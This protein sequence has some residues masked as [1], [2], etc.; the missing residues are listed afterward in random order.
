M[1][2]EQ[3]STEELERI[4]AGGAV[5]AESP[6]PG[7]APDLSGYSTEALERIAA[8][9]DP[10]WAELSDEQ[11]ERIAAPLS[12]LPEG[13][14]RHLPGAVGDTL[15][16]AGEAVTGLLSG[17][18][19]EAASQD[20]PGSTIPDRPMSG[21]GGDGDRQADATRS[22]LAPQTQ[23]MSDMWAGDSGE[24]R[25]DDRPWILRHP[26]A[27][28]MYE[29]TLGNVQRVHS[30]LFGAVEEAQKAG[31]GEAVTTRIDDPERREYI[32]PL[33]A[34]G[35]AMAG[36]GGPRYRDIMKNAGVRFGE[37]LADEDAHKPWYSLTW[38]GQLGKE[39]S[40]AVGEYGTDPLVIGSALHGQQMMRQ[41]VEAI[42]Q[43]K[44]EVFN[45]FVARGIDVKAAA[46]QADNLVN[47]GLAYA[48]DPKLRPI[49]MVVNE[50]GRIA[51][52]SPVERGLVNPLLVK[53]RGGRYATPKPGKIRAFGQR[54]ADKIRRDPRV[55]RP[56][57]T[58]GTPTAPPPTPPPPGPSPKIPVPAPGA[59]PPASAPPAA[60]PVAPPPTPPTP[61]PPVAEGGG[62]TIIDAE[63]AARRGQPRADTWEYPIRNIVVMDRVKQFKR[64]AD[65]VTGVVRGQALQ[66]KFQREPQVQPILVWERLD[67]KN[68]V[69]TGR[70]RFDLAKRNGEE[71]IPAQVV[72]EADG[73]TQEM[74][75][76]YD[77][78]ANIRDQQGE[79]SDY[80]HFFRHYPELT[81]AQAADK[82]LVARS[83]GQAGW[84]LG[85]N[86]TDDLYSLYQAGRIAEAK[87]VAIAGAAP[88]NAALQAAGIEFARE[89]G[90]DAADV[91]NYLQDL[92]RQAAERIEQGVQG[93]LVGFDDAAMNESKKVA[94]AASRRQ[95]D[96]KRKLQVLRAGVKMGSKKFQDLAQQY[97][98]NV[99]DPDA[100]ER[101]QVEVLAELEAWRRWATDPSKVAELQAEV[102]G[103]KPA[104]DRAA[105]AD[106]LEALRE[107]EAEG[108][109]EVREGRAPYGSDLA[110]GGRGESAFRHTLRLA[111]ESKRGGAATVARAD[112]L[113]TRAMQH[114][115]RSL[116][117][118]MDAGRIDEAEAARRWE[119]A[120]AEI[121][122]G[123]KKIEKRQA[124]AT[125]RA[126]TGDMFAPPGPAPGMLFEGR[127][128]YGAAGESRLDAGGASGRIADS[129][130]VFQFEATDNDL[131]KAAAARGVK[132][133]EQAAA[134]ADDRRRLDAVSRTSGQ[135]YPSG[136]DRPAEVG[137][138]EARLLTPDEARAAQAQALQN[139]FNA[140]YWAQ[141][142]AH[143]DTVSSVIAERLKRPDVRGWN[144]RG[145]RVISPRD[146]AGVHMTIDA[147]TQEVFAV[148]YLDSGNRTIETRIV[149][150]GL[151]DSSLVH[152]REI[153]G[154]MPKG[155]VMVVT[156]HNHP[157]G[158]PTPSSEDVRITRQLNEAAKLANVKLSDHVVTN[159]GKYY[160]MR[161]EG[162]V[163]FNADRQGPDEPGVIRQSEFRDT[164]EMPAQY[165]WEAVPRESLQ[166]IRT[167]QDAAGVAEA[168]SQ[169]AAP[170][171][172]N[173]ILYLNAKKRLTAV[174]RVP[175]EKGS[176]GITQTVAQNAGRHGASAYIAV[177]QGGDLP[178]NVQ[179]ARQL[180]ASAKT[181]D[182]G[183]LDIMVAPVLADGA[184]Q[185][186]RTTTL[187]P[188][189][190]Q[191]GY[192]SMLER[193][194]V[195]F[196]ERAAY[197]NVRE[198]G[199]APGY[200]ELVRNDDLVRL[201]VEAE[202]WALEH[203]PDEAHRRDA[204]KVW[205]K[206]AI[207]DLRDAR[208]R[209]ARPMPTPSPK[210]PGVASGGM[211]AIPSA[212]FSRPAGKD[213][214]PAAPAKSKAEERGVMQ[215]GARALDRFL[216]VARPGA[217]K[218]AEVGQEIMRRRIAEAAR[219]NE[220]WGNELN[221]A[222]WQMMFAPEAARWGFVHEIEAGQQA[223]KPEWVEFGQKMRKFLD[224]ERDAIRAI[225]P[226]ALRRFYETYFPHLW[227]SG[228]DTEMQ[229]ASIIGRRPLKGTADFLKQRTYAT[230][231]EGI[232]AGLVPVTPNPAEM[233]LLK[234]AEMRRFRMAHEILN[235]LKARG[236]LSF[237]YARGGRPP[238]GYARIEDDMFR[239]ILP[240]EITVQEAYDEILMQGLNRV[241]TGMGI[242]VQTKMKMSGHRW[243][244]AREHPPQIGRK[245]GGPESVLIHEIGHHLGY[246]YRLYDV[247][248]HAGKGHYRE[249]SRGPRKGERVFVPDPEAVAHRKVIDAEWR[250][251]ADARYAGKEDKVS[252]GFK[253]YVRKETEKE[254]VLLEAFL[255]APDLF[256]EVAPRL[257]NAFKQFMGSHPETVELMEL[258][259]SL[260]LGSN[261]DKVQVPGVTEVGRYYAPEPVAR[262]LNNHLS[263]GLRHL[264]GY[265]A[266]R[267]LGNAVNQAQLSVSAFHAGN[268]LFDNMASYI[269][270]GLHEILVTGHVG[271]G[272]KHIVEGAT[273]ISAVKV[274]RS[275][276]RTMAAYRGKKSTPEIETLLDALLSA[277]GRV[278]MDPMYHNQAVK[279]LA[280]D[281]VK[282][283]DSGA[284][285]RAGL[286]GKLALDVA[287]SVLELLNKPLMEYLVPRMK[288]GLFDELARYEL[289]RAQEENW[290]NEVLVKRLMMA[291]DS[292]ENRQGQMSYDNLFWNRA[293]KDCLM[294]SMRS[295]GWNLGTWQEYGGAL[296]DAITTPVRALKGATRKPLLN[297]EGKRMDAP[298]DWV[299]M[300][301]TYVAG[302]AFV[303][304]MLGAMLYYL[305]N[306]RN[307]FEDPEFSGARDLVFVP[308]G[309]MRPDGSRDRIALPTY[310]KDL[311]AYGTRPTQTV[312]NKLHPLWNSIA[313]LLQN[314]DFYGTQV[315]DPDAPLGDQVLQAAEYG[316][317][318][319]E[320]FSVRNYR[321]QI[322]SGQD[323]QRAVGAFLGLIPAP[324]YVAR[325]KTLRS[326]LDITKRRAPIGPRSRDD[327][328]RSQRRRELVRAMRMDWPHEITEQDNLW[329]GHDGINDIRREAA[330]TY[331]QAA[332]SR[333]T[334]EDMARIYERATPREQAELRPIV[335]NRMF[336]A[337]VK[338]LI[339]GP[340]RNRS[341][342]AALRQA[343]WRSH[344]DEKPK[345]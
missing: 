108:G 64:G 323:P 220:R 116:L 304:A 138:G 198:G 103:T 241:A 190:G 31:G 230:F 313:Y 67:G 82:G 114:K 59:T 77:A 34:F 155:T 306:R 311:Y 164:P 26:V 120:Q 105:P 54:V 117:D 211:A 212:A 303:T 226:Y 289:Q 327:A 154:N 89:Q 266:L 251:L 98:I 61:T 163:E 197:G 33:A 43:A 37:D 145:V 344:P 199:A 175:V 345:D 287:G 302:A 257:Y 51:R 157:S 325:S 132:P 259:P 158:D 260:V 189:S 156:S 186:G 280:R 338:R 234:L 196:E 297:A 243:G 161:E 159:A 245:F 301:M 107:L 316:V 152:P 222:V 221:R 88:G 233:V 36:Y 131:F 339:S 180:V 84:S 343:Y 100:I 236:Q 68:E 282:W 121:E 22:A 209:E 12:P 4:A 263:P 321:Q 177:L 160:S 329:F 246:R 151:V 330:M 237:V 29:A 296:M 261:A 134:A 342:S 312:I 99:K 69:V 229:I 90:V 290:S 46:I 76:R 140:E 15:K 238:A 215:S 279:T 153:F 224:A 53:V 308:T 62:T 328:A 217:R 144:M 242:D 284:L 250:A 101:A 183:C 208:E 335:E 333:L 270:L 341:G 47:G 102:R 42:N 322:E 35:R 78:E 166:R 285:K 119:K 133:D 137:A 87:A 305:Y 203:V 5:V 277:G 113:A 228:P 143:G 150:V 72:R 201:D 48:V 235:D 17:S 232:E 79:I 74:A 244:E 247:L 8:G 291:W 162:L 256:Q 218:G 178:Y 207:R 60:P 258:R 252:D 192:V 41:T 71:T 130:G 83:K 52:A 294:L 25:K 23:A 216:A 6:G 115:A 111:A 95:N 57:V 3:Y 334:P 127:G 337:S 122:R 340:E 93:V 39:F 174:T 70:N 283:R 193:G 315:I 281:L 309:A 332:F 24:E 298:N 20:A 128:E 214:R 324:A 225:N 264:I 292:V 148:Q 239:V 181:Y 11:L 171:R 194:L 336:S 275:G 299:T 272:L 300:K 205:L 169:H 253:K 254:A 310:W 112:V 13:T 167:P 97:G 223:S 125:P 149:T 30:G 202:A 141:A 118:A 317:R 96:I 86:A 1:A 50:A 81:E 219:D 265:N 173:L 73:F 146:A 92:Q 271:S 249:I 21:Q 9:A 106:A 318:T 331:M 18:T 268:V 142:L 75:E 262:L 91:E 320:P 10:Q 136:Q 187:A 19:E 27:H 16:S 110:A 65:P 188:E 28:F 58:G 56:R 200:G 293:T 63:T 126:K 227:E 326:I 45:A 204:K 185:G 104:A 124:A 288:L 274:F 129:Q 278:S 85:R 231:K 38:L 191:D 276:R 55:F 94:K 14:M 80:A 267:K 135:P 139:P 210:A 269:G 248:R 240:P 286:T 172:F 195:A 7:N 2:W 182:V 123:Q 295:V 49:E 184:V 44:Q 40:H 66:G 307:P 319:F 165:G 176:Y 168:M 179:G 314:E 206:N 213:G 170:G 255:H 109:G 273:P 147:G 32:G